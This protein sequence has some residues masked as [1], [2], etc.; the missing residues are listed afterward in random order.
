MNWQTPTQNLANAGSQNLTAIQRGAAQSQL[1]ARREQ[2]RRDNQKVN[3][4]LHRAVTADENISDA[5]RV[6][7]QAALDKL[8]KNLGRIPLNKRRKS[9]TM[10]SSGLHHHTS[11]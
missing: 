6:I 7:A 8:N 5:D 11:E 1:D 2:G 3:R 10:Y 9:W 4:D